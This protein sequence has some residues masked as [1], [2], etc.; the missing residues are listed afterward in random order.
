MAVC[1]D[2]KKPTISFF[3]KIFLICISLIFFGSE[4][5]FAIE[6][7]YVNELKGTQLAVN[8]FF[9]VSDEKFNNTSSWNLIQQNISV[10]DIISF[11]INF[12]T[13]IYFYNQPFNCTVNFKVYIYGNQGDTSQITDSVTHANISLKI[14]YDTVTGKPYKGIALYKFTGAYKYKVKILSISSPQFSPP[15]PAIFRLKGQIIVDR[16][17][18][19]SDNSTD[20]TRYTIQNSNQLKLNWTPST[21]PGAEMF[22][23]EYTQID[24]SSQA[25]ASIRLYQSGNDYTVPP[26][27]LTK[28]FKN[29]STRITTA[30]SGYLLDIPYDSGYILF[31]LRGVQDSLGIRIEGNWNYSAKLYSSNC[32][33]GC[34]TGV[35]FFAGH[36]VSLNWQYSVTFAEEGKRKEVISY[37]DG[38][39]RNRQSVTINNT[40]NKTIVQ[41]SVYDVL[42]RPAANILPVPTND[43]TL[44]YFKTFNK[45]NTGDPYSFSD[46]PSVSCVT[47]AAQMSN[48]S[49]ASKYYSSNNSF[50]SSYYYAKYIP[51][52]QNYPFTVTE[53]VADNTGRIKAQGGVGSAFQL[54]SNHETSYFYGKPTQTE[55]DR[56]FGS[57]AGNVSHYLKNMVVDPNG[58]ISVSYVDASGKTIATALAG[59]TPV[60]LHQIPSGAGASVQVTNDLMTPQD[61]STNSGNYTISASST[62][63]APVTG[64]YVMNY[65]IDPLRYEKLYGPN[66]DSVIC[67]NCYYDLLI[68]VK[69]NCENIL[70][71]ESRPAGNVFD[72][73]CANGAGSLQGTFSVAVSKIGEYY[74]YYE[75]KVSKDA[76]NFYDSVHLVKNSDIKRLNSFLL[77]E[78]KQTDFYG[79]Y[80]NCQTCFD[81]LGTKDE[82]Y[83]LF[84]SQYVNDSI[85]FGTQDSV[86]VL[87][88]YDSLYAHCQAIQSECV[89]QNVCDEKLDLLK[90]DV[91]PGGQYALYD[92]NYV[93]QELPI[94][95]LAKRNQISSFPDEMGIPDSLILADVNGED[96]L[97]IPVKQLNDSMFIANWKDSWADSLVRLHPEYCH[98]LWCLV[99]DSSYAFDREIEDWSDADTAMTRGW[100]DPGNYKALLDKDPFFKTGANGANLYLRMKDSLRFFSRTMIR[101]AQSDKNIL[102]FIDVVLYCKT[103]TNGWDGCIPDSACRSRNREWFLYKELYLN[104]KQ[105]FYETARRS[106]TDPVFNNCV[107]C[108]IGPDLLAVTGAVCNPPPVSDL[109]LST[110]NN[111]NYTI[112]YANIL[113]GVSSSVLVGVEYRNNC[114]LPGCEGTYTLDTL[115]RKIR[116]SEFQ[117]SFLLTSEQSNPR[118]VSASCDT[119]SYTA[120]TDSTCNTFCPGGVYD[121]Y[122]RDSISL[123]VEYGNPSTAPSGTPTGYSNCRFYPVFNLKTGAQ[124]SCKFFNVWVC[125]YDSIC[126]SP[127]GGGYGCGSFLDGQHS[128]GG[129]YQYPDNMINLSNVAQSGAVQIYCDAIEIPN[130]FTV[131]DG[132]NNFVASTEWMG[133]ADYGGPWG[134]SLN[135]PVHQTISFTKQ[136]NTYTLKVE[137]SPPSNISD[138]WNASISC[139]ASGGGGNNCIIQTNYPSSCPAS[140]DDTLYRNKVRRYPE[141][142]NPDAVINNA[143]NPQQNSAA[144]EQAILDECH[145]NCEAQADVWISTLKK[146]NLSSSD[147][148]QLRAALVDICSK[149]CSQTNIFG[150]SSIPST[151]PA[152]YHSFEEAIIGILGPGAINDSCTAELLSN[153]Y[154]YNHQPVYIDRQ[155]VETDYSICHRIS[156]K[157]QEFL[158][159]GFTGSF[160]QYLT[161]RYGSAYGLDSLELDDLLNSC[162]N[163]NGI[164]KNDLVLPL[165]FDPASSDCLHCDSLQAALTAFKNKFPGQD[166]SKQNYE[167]LFSNFFNHRFGFALT[168]DQY[169]TFLDSCSANQSYTAVLCN[170]PVETEDTTSGNGNGCLAEQ[171]ANALTNATNIYLAYIDSVR[172]DFRDAWMTKCLNVQPRLTMTADLYEYHYTLYYYDQSGSL[173]KTIPPEGVSLLSDIDIQYV[174][175]FRKLK[176]EG[177][178]QYSDSIKFNNNGYAQFSMSTPANPFTVEAR[179]D[180]SSNADQ[181]ILSQLSEF[182]A[183]GLGGAPVTI[184]VGYVLSVIGNQLKLET[185]SYVIV[186]DTSIQTFVYVPK[187]AVATSIL[188]I[189][190]LLSVDTWKHF[191]MEYTGDN[192]DPWK[193]FINGNPVVLQYSINELTA[194]SSITSSNLIVGSY[195]SFTLPAPGK[196]RGTIKNLRIYDRLLA[197]NELRQNAFNACQVPSNSSG[198][199]FWSALNSATN[200]LV[201]EQITRQDGVLTGFTWTA[202]NGKFPNHRLPTTYQYNSLNQVLQQYSPDGDTS[203]FFYDRLGRLIVSQNKEQKTNASYSGTANRF[204]YTNYDLLGRIQ[205]VG[206]KSTPSADIRTID[207]LDTTAVKNWLA[208][209]TN[210]QITKTI[211]DNPI[212]TYQTYST[213]RK[214]VVASIYLENATDTEGDSTLYSYDIL[215]NVKTLVQHIK[216]L[217][218]IDA[219]NGKKQVDYDYDLVSGK[220]NMVSYQKGKGDQFFYKYQYDADNRVIASYSSRDKLIWIADASYTYYLHGPL[221][222]T[223]LGNYKVQGI[224]YAYTLQG[225]L[226][227]INSDSL[228]QLYDM[229]NDGRQNTTYSRVSRDV[230]AFKLGYYTND[231]A[232]I[233][234]AGANAF[235]NKNYTAPSGLDNSGNQLFN[236]N[237]SFTNLALSKINN[238]AAIGYSYGYDQL[239]RL[240]EMRQHTTGTTSGWSNT[241]I[242]TAYRESIAYD[243]NGNILQYLRNGSAATINM[244]SMNYKY[245][246]DGSGNLVNNKLNQVRDQV[247]SSNYAVD[248]DNQSANNY[249]Y[250]LIGNL[251]TDAAESISNIDW[252][253]Y[254]KIKKIVKSAI[255]ITYSYDAGGNRTSKK[256][257]GSA[258]TTTIYV[259][260]AQGNVLAV[261]TK[262]ASNNLLWSEQH[263]YGSSRLGIWSW[264]TTVPAVQTLPVQ[265]SLMLGNRTYELT[266]HLGNVLSTISDK[267]IGN[268]SSG[269][270]NYYFAEVL[271][272]TDY[273]PFGMRMPG[274]TYTYVNTPPSPPG[275]GTPASPVTLYQHNFNSGPY[276]HP[277]TVA[278]T[279]LSSYLTNSGW[280]NSQ[281]AWVNSTGILSVSGSTPTTTTLTL[282]LNAQSGYNVSFTSF[283]FSCKS[284]NNGYT[285][286]S[287]SINGIVVGSGTITVNNGSTLVP[288][289]PL[290]VANAVNNLTGTIT[291]VITLSGPNH[292][293]NG[294]FRFDDFILNGY[295]QQLGV[296][297]T[298]GKKYRYG[299]NDKEKSDEIYGE[300]NAYDFG[301]RIQDSRLGRWFSL[302]PLQKKYPGESNYAFVSGNPILYKDADGRDKIITIT[303]I[304]KDG[305]TTQIQKIDKSYFKYSWSMREDG[306]YF[307]KADV[308]QSLIIDLRSVNDNVAGNNPGGIIQYS[309][310]EVNEQYTSWW[311]YSIFSDIN[312]SGDNSDEVAYGYRIYGRGHDMEWQNGLPQAAPGTE[313]ID[314]EDWFD[315]VGAFS[316]N[317]GLTETFSKVVDKLGPLS[318]DMQQ[319][320]KA[321]DIFGNQVE[322][323]TDAAIAAAKLMERLKAQ[324]KDLPAGK[325]ICPACKDVQD[326]THVDDVNG[327]GTFEKLR[328][329]PDSS[330]KTPPPDTGK[331]F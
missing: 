238:G 202:T 145:D 81:K 126:T 133:Y 237:I 196:L 304:A 49:G 74:V 115:F 292:N 256:V 90:R 170:Q 124:T 15:L 178:Y 214:R 71:T 2:H 262:N 70:K 201:P 30:A 182:S 298:A 261:Y 242:I 185:Y 291:V 111:V 68:T 13:T 91:S 134:S 100:F 307:R 158:S 295:V 144:S 147:S 288:V 4:K 248:I 50:Q 205:E 297:A 24:Y 244:D 17:Y 195:T 112:E 293:P 56:L 329:K 128:G 249:N 36:E 228:S 37:F 135:T 21:Y 232:P 166:S 86:W 34:P 53:Y 289:G 48:S 227:G 280:T 203:Q 231:Y 191:A 85:T 294:A 282:T 192:T 219:T 180:L 210:R 164:L 43:S 245:N 206:E 19:F 252:T 269:K 132:N 268:D 323:L 27:S 66:K 251:K 93:L 286:W 255:N 173:V 107:N 208:S 172:R 240:V 7:P 131:Y 193:I 64:S 184:H 137:T 302:D 273:Y 229:A 204:S 260:D 143:S 306:A 305:A 119:L 73:S 165:I 125:V 301:S 171:F 285:N 308:K 186:L 57:E 253:E 169:K 267:K 12:D 218:A 44:H 25:G 277:Y 116:R 287:M 123:Y 138:A 216:A 254:G 79:C 290:N 89:P 46:L 318:K 313:S 45:N 33:S 224:D 88:L 278:P 272:Q 149:G 188:P 198:L 148:T 3:R 14:Q 75:L 233:G 61:F 114:F 118:I 72:T 163:C 189:T 60:N 106:S 139:V 83:T 325:A 122:D 215:G 55:L 63:L 222:R 16:K 187:V 241:N 331:N 190:N 52:A 221:A 326:S 151:I 315:L 161:Q 279:T 120:F 41:E 223:E 283:N 23:L 31:R 271:S 69:D 155:I 117:A 113:Q 259:R 8:N 211:Y 235:A 217:I 80:S 225:W 78:L 250:D 162:T 176:N 194:Q 328:P 181:V 141:Y 270:V 32:T 159:S 309:S 11:E 157:K 35:V 199:L 47:N 95:I 236:G 150:T 179:I 246:R 317:E 87:S 42:G 197:A 226:K 310:E 101:L 1:F 105:R 94:N 121:P 319:V 239:N 322:N 28:W 77:D 97:R 177:C 109:S 243:A 129:Y 330:S 153:P 324:S 274:R 18:K 266:N 312:I 276:S 220:V 59:S 142:V 174:Q 54:G 82:F 209:G 152:T 258:D 156:L 296:A 303:I 39:L 38:S 265:D 67:N 140:G 316:P 320:Q 300:G 213:S 327:K 247:S 234:G 130:R 58:Q 264:D 314:L 104:L 168:F 110:T 257:T 22:D 284:Q 154:P 51:D 200:N 212:N 76:L 20:V 281:S 5:V 102:Q 127:G 98:Y 263:L 96:S 6:E 99:N 40:D 175:N 62:F 311:D 146:C 275:G 103:Q 230:Y 160:H 167:I 207:L 65:N 29:N 183:I 84:K 321:F 136:T 108:F 26:D 10:N 9:T 299:F 92:T